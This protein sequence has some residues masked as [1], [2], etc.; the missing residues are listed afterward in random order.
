MLIIIIIIPVIT[1]MQVIY[2]LYLKQTIFIGY[3]VLRLFII[4]NLCYM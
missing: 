3:I 1:C 4:Y 2:N